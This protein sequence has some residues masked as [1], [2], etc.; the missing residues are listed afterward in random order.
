MGRPTATV[1]QCVVLAD[2]P[3][4]GSGAPSATLKPVATCGGRPVLAWLLREFVRYGVTE[5][6]LLT[7]RLSA[8]V[9]R[10]AAD[11]QSSLPRPARV[12]LS[13]PPD[14]AGTGG[15][16]FH[17]RKHL[18]DRFLLCAEGTLFDGNLANL[19]A[20]AAADGPGVL[21]RIMLRRPDEDARR[22][23]A[24][25]AGAALGGDHVTASPDLPAPSSGVY[26]FRN[27]VASRLTA[28]CSLEG[29]VLPRLAADGALRATEVSGTFVGA[30]APG[31]AARMRTQLL[32]RLHRRA[33]FLDRDGVL[34]V[35]RGYVGSLDRF[36]W[37]DGALDAIR[38]ATQ[39][40]WHV[41]IATNQSGVARGLYDESAV[42][43]LLDWIGDEARRTGGTID[44]W[45]Y[46]PF[47]PEA[48]REAYRQVHA[49][50]KPLPGMLLD[51]MGA[52][53]VDPSRAVMV[54]D[55]ET[56]MAAAAAAGMPGHLFQGGN[57]LS[58]VRPLLDAQV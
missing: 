37:V 19:L 54:G 18:D 5:F 36:E 52:W 41:F 24:R 28:S 23:A 35:D 50:R 27:A 38:H 29:D 3:G 49:W 1:T 16:V 43:A 42:R 8:D 2:G 58:F 45:R 34:N 55:Q 56:D 14:G 15:S 4:A 30:G 33:L 51:L 22:G 17:A 57:L 39:A 25:Q 47:H 21:G 53:S 48:T 9:E 6:L 31:D 12:T 7:G 44:D 40:G 10:T 11:I 20:D 46:C 13:Q 26:L 32:K